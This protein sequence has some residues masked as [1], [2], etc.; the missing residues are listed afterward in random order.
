MKT[1]KNI[2]LIS[3]FGLLFI[4]CSKDGEQG[5]TGAQGIQGES[6]VKG[7]DGQDGE[8]GLSG[9]DGADGADGQNGTDGTQGETGTTNVIYSEWFPSQFPDDIV[10]GNYSFPINTPELTEEILA[11]G[12][13]LVYSRRINLGGI[14]VVRQLPITIF[15]SV[16][17]SYHTQILID[18][19]ISISFV[20]RSIDGSPV[21]STPYDSFR[22][23]L[24]PGGIPSSGK[25][26]AIDFTKM[27]YEEV[28]AH[29]GIED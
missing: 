11:T 10:G 5:N 25:S 29:F 6:G 1:L 13:V 22:Y 12:V 4:A 20:V 15:E 7:A 9:E 26:N 2:L 21:G 24:V 28:A 27:T 3:L 16:Q 23:V 18:D 8:Q 17:Q 19:N 14:P